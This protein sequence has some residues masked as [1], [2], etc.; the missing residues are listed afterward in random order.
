M[1]DL[2]TQRLSTAANYRP[3]G[4]QPGGFVWIR[5]WS[6]LRRAQNGRLVANSVN[7]IHSGA[8]YLGPVPGPH[9]TRVLQSGSAVPSATLSATSPGVQSTLPLV[10]GIG[11]SARPTV[12]G[13][14]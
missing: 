5:P 6:Q 12:I 14:Q 3:I 4:W 9:A 11:L 7:G 2:S 13:P 10:A 8:R 1:R